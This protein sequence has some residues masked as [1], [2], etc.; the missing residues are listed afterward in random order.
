M[1]VFQSTRASSKK[2]MELALAFKCNI[3]RAQFLATNFGEGKV[4]QF[5][6]NHLKM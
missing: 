5:K 4:L 2:T 1:R 6:N 3:Q